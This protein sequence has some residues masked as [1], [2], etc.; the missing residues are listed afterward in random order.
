[1]NKQI[2]Y[3]HV[4][5]ASGE[6]AMLNSY[7]KKDSVKGI[8]VCQICG[9]GSLQKSNIKKHVEGVHFPGH[10]DHKCEICDKDFNGKNSLSV[11]LYKFHGA[12]S[13]NK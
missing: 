4:S 10:F 13:A 2:D 12:G 11:H 7:I 3:Y 6:S 5:V 9:K 8:F 1:M